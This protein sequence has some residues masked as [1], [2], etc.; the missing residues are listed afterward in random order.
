[1][2]II[3][4]AKLKSLRKELDV[5]HEKLTLYR[6][7]DQE[8]GKLPEPQSKIE[9]ISDE[10]AEQEKSDAKPQLDLSIVH[11]IRV[12]KLCATFQDDLNLYLVQESLLEN[13]GKEVWE[14]CR[15]FGLENHSVV[16]YTFYQI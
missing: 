6:I 4:K 16:E 11:P 13:G 1:M 14:Y 9:E 10:D 2:K 15:S 5:L 3:E 12:V 8:R 7:L